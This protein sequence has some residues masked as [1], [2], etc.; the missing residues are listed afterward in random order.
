MKE[1]ALSRSNQILMR[2][3]YTDLNGF[4]KSWKIIRKGL[5]LQF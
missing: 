2:D 3:L 1:T 4:P 5:K